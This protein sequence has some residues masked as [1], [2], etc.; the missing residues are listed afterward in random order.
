MQAE[1]LVRQE[2]KCFKTSFSFTNVKANDK[3]NRFFRKVS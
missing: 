3:N 1:F 2:D